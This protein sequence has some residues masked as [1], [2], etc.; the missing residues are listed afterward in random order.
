MKI[1]CT[2]HTQTT[3]IIIRI[4]ILRLLLAVCIFFLPHVSSI[5][6][7]I[8]ILSL[9]FIK[10]IPFLWICKDN[11]PTQAT[12]KVYQRFDKVV[13]LF[14]Y[15]LCYK[16]LQLHS[17]LSKEYLTALFWVLL[18]RTVGVMMYLL[19][20]NRT[21]LMIGVDLFKEWLLI[22]IVCKP[23]SLTFYTLITISILVKLWIEYRF[24]VQ[25]KGG[26]SIFTK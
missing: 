22:F 14:G 1:D 5:S 24:H 12:N 23:Y 19:T 25:K 16:L 2:N 15:V 13:D 11:L 17:L 26:I 3:P 4:C 8:A 21:Y 20:N 18:L 9:D 6:K 7:I 10:N